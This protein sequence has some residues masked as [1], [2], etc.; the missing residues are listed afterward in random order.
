LL[1]PVAS[2]GVGKGWTWRKGDESPGVPEPE[3]LKRETSSDLCE[4][5][6]GVAVPELWPLSETAEVDA[7]TAE[8]VAVA[9]ILDIFG[10]A[11]C[12]GTRCSRREVI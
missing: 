3:P 10:A 4:S 1:L 9:E 5:V 12:E 6:C 11:L 7:A 2:V 8:V